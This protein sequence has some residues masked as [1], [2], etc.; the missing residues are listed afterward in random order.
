MGPFPC[1]TQGMPRLRSIPVVLLLSSLIWGAALPAQTTVPASFAELKAQVER[2][3]ELPASSRVAALNQ[4]SRFRTEEALRYLLE[5]WGRETESIVRS[6][7]LRQLGMHRDERVLEHL[8]AAWE[9]PKSSTLHSAAAYGLANQG[10]AGLALLLGVLDA[11][12]AED[13][14]VRAAL[15]ALRSHGGDAGIQ[16]RLLALLEHPAPFVRQE[17]L[18]QL[19][20]LGHE[21]APRTAREWAASVDFEQLPLARPTVFYAIALDASE[22]DLPALLRLAKDGGALVEGR[23]RL[24][25]SRHASAAAQL[26]DLLRT[27]LQRSDDAGERLVALRLLEAAPPIENDVKLLRRVLQDSAGELHVA[28]LESLVRREDRRSLPL[29]E[30]SL[31]D[32]DP[33]VRSTALR[34]A[35]ALGRK[36]SRAWPR[37]L[38]RAA[39]DP[40]LGVALTAFELLRELRSEQGLKLAWDWLGAEAWQKRSAAVA[41][42]RSVPHVDSIGPLI[43]RLGDERGRVAHEAMGALQELTGKRFPAR[44]Y[45]ERWWAAEKRRF[46]L[47][48]RVA[49]ESAESPGAGV[50]TFYGLPIE[51]DAVCF[52]I[53]VS[54]SMS[55]KAG[56]GEGIPKIDAA[57]RALQG[58]IE[59]CDPELAFN[60]I[61]FQNDARSWEEKLLEAT[62]EARRRAQDFVRQMRAGGGTN[63]HAAL[64]LA[65]R[66]PRVDTIYLLSDGAPSAGEIRDVQRLADEV[67]RWNRLRRIKIHGISI[68]TDSVL[69][70]RLAEESGGR[71][72]RWI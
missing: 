17:A 35:H 41:F 3:R 46:R 36:D 1:E 48:E 2:E 8:R 72:Q 60:L 31:D 23:M 61:W 47:P 71:Y 66:D 14:R 49:S 5:L 38:V 25:A 16:R 65:F 30:R 20:D 63:V 52:V 9:D 68:G 56:T 34:A 15:Y 57:K 21:A 51:S 29:V 28:V 22:R 11:G 40:D 26:L 67:R 13:A 39:E 19:A 7:V 32:P 12:A 43:D 62:E 58:V 53:D 54:G 50:V 6:T 33:L 69:L 4:F 55:T 64:E 27:A 24:F 44:E 10:D 59:R 37:R 70:R 18:Q 42:V 45:W